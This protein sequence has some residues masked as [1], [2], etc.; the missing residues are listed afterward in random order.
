MYG[1]AI[2]Q[3]SPLKLDAS[4]H[5]P[6]TF[7]PSGS[8]NEQATLSGLLGELHDLSVFVVEGG[9]GSSTAYVL[10]GRMDN[11]DGWAG[12]IGVGISS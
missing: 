8:A 2:I 12:L 5:L 3:V 11:D 10:L 9:P 7:R 1:R 4:T 6:E